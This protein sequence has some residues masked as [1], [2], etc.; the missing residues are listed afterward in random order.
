MFGTAG[1]SVSSDRRDNPAG[2]GDAGSASK[3]ERGG[4]TLRED[5]RAA[6]LRANLKKR[7][8][9]ARARSDGAGINDGEPSNGTGDAEV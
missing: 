3:P 8:A 2:K 6:Q 1:E 9:L 7:K 4:S 5:R